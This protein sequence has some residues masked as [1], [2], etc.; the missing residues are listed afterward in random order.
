MWTFFVRKCKD[1]INHWRDYPLRTGV[2][3]LGRYRI[4]RFIGMGSYG[5]AYACTDV[6]TKDKV[7]MKRNMP[8]KNEIG[9]QLLERESMILQKLSHPQIPKWIRYEKKGFD[10]ALLMELV[11][12]DNLEHKMMEQGQMYSLQE[13]LSV[14][15]QLLQPLDY[16]HQAGYVHRD[17]RIPN[18]LEK[19]GRLYL[20][21]YGLSCRIG[22]QLP[23]ALRIGLKETEPLKNKNGHLPGGGWSGDKLLMRRPVPE[24]DLYGLGHLFLF[25]MYVSYEHHEGQEERSWEEELELPPAVKRFV[26]RLLQQSEPRWASAAQCG[27]ELEQL[28]ASLAE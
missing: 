12:G 17:V 27:Q 4:E 28:L 22:E 8:S 15:K 16:L 14:I 10:E 25:M 21:D 9:R 1:M 6:V 23:E 3:W 20:I 11:D 5:Q 24:S 2:I 18:V 19:G 13:T 26:R 7:L